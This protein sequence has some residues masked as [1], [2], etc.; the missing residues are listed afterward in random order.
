MTSDK[1]PAVVAAE[2]A[3]RK[4]CKARFG[5]PHVFV[6][7]VIDGDAPSDA[8]RLDGPETVI[9]RGAPARIRVEDDQVSK[10]H[11]LIRV[12]GSVCTLRDLGSLNGTFLNG[13]RIQAGLAQR[14][15]HLD[16][17]QVGETRLLLL[18]GRFRPPPRPS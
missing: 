14:L 6:L 5:A 4:A 16:E 13:R 2:T 17:I 3:K 7:T 12:E 8:F 11:S 18:A 1:G 10:Q 15:R 9:G